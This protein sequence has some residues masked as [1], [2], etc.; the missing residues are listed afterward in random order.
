MEL[1]ICRL[2]LQADSNA[3][4]LSSTKNNSNSCMLIQR[5]IEFEILSDALLLDIMLCEDCQN[6]LES[7]HKF[8]KACI[9]NDK[10]FRELFSN[11]LSSASI[12]AEPPIGDQH[13]PGSLNG[14]EAAIS[15]EVSEADDDQASVELEDVKFEHPA[16]DSVVIETKPKKQSR[17]P[18]IHRKNKQD[19]R[20]GVCTVC[21]E[22]RKN[23][24]EHMKTHSTN[25]PY[26]CPY[27]PL[28]FRNASNCKSHV[29]IHTREK[30][31]Q[32]NICDKEFALRNGLK[33][34][35]ATHTR[36]QVFLCHCGKSFYQRTAYA[37]HARK[38]V[39]K[40]AIKCS[41][42]KM[43]FFSNAELRYHFQKHT[44]AVFNCGVCGR[45]F[46]R[47]SNLKKHT[48]IHDRKHNQTQET[49]SS[50]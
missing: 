3:V 35:L 49:T 45:G 4:E 41:E 15:V 25:R 2:C 29:N 9:E 48:A 16:Q 42:C 33:Q 12:K 14:N 13:A 43:L 38:H 10:K 17:Q 1:A 22:V 44:G 24:Y 46:Y 40:P 5:Y 36:N 7:W 31:Y 47:K 20:A 23:M 18:K 30:L 50:N 28:A 11:V 39:E 19:M 6:V 27:C 21:G 34:H 8:Q 26:T 37:R 32:C